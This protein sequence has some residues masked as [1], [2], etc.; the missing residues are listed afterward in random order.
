MKFAVIA[1]L[2]VFGCKGSGDLT[3][4]HP[5]IGQKA[6]NFDLPTTKGDRVKLDQYRGKWVVI[7]FGTSW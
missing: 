1:L 7:H 3:A 2:F 4:D 5:L 6:P